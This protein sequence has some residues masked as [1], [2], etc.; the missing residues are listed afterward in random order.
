MSEISKQALK[1]DNSTSFPNNTT[2][3]ISPTILRAFNVNMIDSLVDEIGY[4]ADSASWN[5][6]IGNLNTY[7]ASFA[8]SLTQL[9]AFT[10]SQLVINTGVNSFTQSAMEI[11][12]ELK[13][14]IDEEFHSF[15][16]FFWENGFIHMNIMLESPVVTITEKALD[17]AE[18]EKLPFEY[19]ATLKIILDALRIK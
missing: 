8:P 2:G 6:S 4:N 5:V 1:V 18:V 10:A 15:I 17:R 16:M 12:P 7:T 19:Q 11:I 9:N 14:Q 3:Y 13:K